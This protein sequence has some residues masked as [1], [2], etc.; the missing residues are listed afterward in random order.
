[1]LL[2]LIKTVLVWLVFWLIGMNLMGI[3]IGAIFD[4]A[5]RTDAATHPILRDEY[6]KRKLARTVSMVLFPML[7]AG[8]LLFVFMTWGTLMLVAA[9]M[10]TLV[11]IPEQFT[12]AISG[13]R[14][15]TKTNA[16]DLI[17][18]PLWFGALLVIWRAWR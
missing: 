16:F 7:L 10:L 17:T 18:T 1:M 11:R 9:L 15:S 2:A 13:E 12:E 4:P 3:A 8:Y 14:A 6:R 5:P